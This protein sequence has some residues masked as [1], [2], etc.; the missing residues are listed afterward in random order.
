MAVTFEEIYLQLIIE[1]K[2][3]VVLVYRE[4]KVPLVRDELSMKEYGFT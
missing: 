4:I 3:L 1:E 2:L